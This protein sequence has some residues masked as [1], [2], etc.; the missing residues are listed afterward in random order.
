M[1]ARSGPITLS[2]TDKLYLYGLF[3]QGQEGDCNIPK[4]SMFDPFGRAKWQAWSRMSGKDQGECVKE[5][6][7]LVVSIVEGMDVSGLSSEHAAARTKFLAEMEAAGAAIDEGNEEEEAANEEDEKGAGASEEAERAALART[8]AHESK[9]SHQ[10][11]ETPAEEPRTPRREETAAAAAAA[12]AASPPRGGGDD[13]HAQLA[14]LEDRL[15][16]MMRRVAEES[17]GR[18]AAGL[19]QV[20]AFRDELHRL[21]ETMDE[22]ARRKQAEYEEAERAWQA[23]MREVQLMQQQLLSKLRQHGIEAADRAPAPGSTQAARNGHPWLWLLFRL[24]KAGVP[25]AVAG[26]VLYRYLRRKRML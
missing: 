26:V 11:G 18:G 8:A 15:G 20:V 4:P 5:Y 1:R 6:A 19:E 12:A 2:N 25:L 9:H 23:Q 7:N 13:A 21:V 17:G 16:D 14:A 22:R 24:V 10:A 3:K